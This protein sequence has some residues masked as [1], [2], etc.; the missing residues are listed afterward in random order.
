MSNKGRAKVLSKGEPGGCV[1]L[2][3]RQ[4][5][6]EDKGPARCY[7]AREVGSDPGFLVRSSQ[8]SSTLCPENN[9]YKRHLGHS[10]FWLQGL[11]P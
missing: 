1:S 11:W 8:E 3:L 10:L 6:R 7:I 2:G 9:M 4:G 5:S